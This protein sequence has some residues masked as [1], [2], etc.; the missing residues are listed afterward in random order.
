MNCYHLSGAASQRETDK[1]YR[2]KYYETYREKYCETFKRSR[3]KRA[4]LWIGAA[5]GCFGFFG[6]AGVARSAPPEEAKEAIVC[7]GTSGEGFSY[8]WGGECW[9]ADGCEPDLDNCAPGQCTPNQ[10]S[11]GCPDCTHTGTYGADCSGFVS[12]AWQVPDPYP[13]NACDVPRYTASMF[14]SNHSYWNVVS[15]NS[16]QPGDAVATS[17]HVILII[18][19]ED[20]FGEHEV[21][22]AKGCVY[23]IVRQSRTF[24]SSYS[25]ARRINLIECVCNEGEQETEDCGDCGTRSR[26]CEEDCFWSGWSPCEGPDPTGEEGSCS[27]EGGVGV[28]ATG[29]RLCVAGWYTCQANMPT[30]EVCDGRD[31]D[32]DGEVDNGTT[33]NLGEGYSCTNNCGEGVTECIEGAVRCVT[34]G[35]EWPDESCGD[36]DPEDDAG[37]EPSDPTKAKGGCGCRTHHGSQKF[38]L[39]LLLLSLCISLFRRR[40]VQKASKNKTPYNKNKTP[41]NCSE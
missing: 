31:N 39:I 30:T 35:T 36:I 29:R 21:V 10:G 8:D 38:P 13:L 26:V 27:V 28:C 5:M 4:L 22:E 7:R 34:P 9:C 3:M 33:E 37:A 14:T 15:M 1:A 32:C 18:G 2:E 6:I 16:L 25:G 11:S 12:K 17:A 23:G 24:S 40:R 41:Y 19:Y 20:A